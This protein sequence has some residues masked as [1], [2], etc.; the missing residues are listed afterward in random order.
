MT[1]LVHDVAAVADEYA[2]LRAHPCAC[3]AAWQ[4]TRQ[5]ALE[6][7]GAI[8]DRLDVEC[9]VCGARASFHFRLR[10]SEEK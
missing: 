1:R 2:H 9:A 5:A 4:L 3:G 8:L 6:E 7:A 10:A